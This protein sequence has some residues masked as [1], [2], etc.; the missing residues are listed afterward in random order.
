MSDYVKKVFDLYPKVLGT[1]SSVQGDLE[2][3]E[4]LAS[5]FIKKYR[6]DVS[7]ADLL[8]TSGSLQA[9]DLISRALVRPGDA[10]MIE[11]PTYSAAI[12]IFRQQNIRLLPVDIHPDGYDLEQVEGWM[13]REKPRLFYMNPTFHNPTGYTVPSRQRKQLVE[14]AE[15]YKCILVEDDVFHDIYFE[16]PPPPPIS[17]L[18]FG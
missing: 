8:I 5:Y 13:K 16:N 1:Y 9:I 4:A 3:R 14:L 2:L 18:D 15:R 11:R 10:V 12:D 6:I 7:A 17:R